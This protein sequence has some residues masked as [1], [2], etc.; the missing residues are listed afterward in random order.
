MQLVKRIPYWAT[1]ALLI[2]MPFHVFLSQSLSL[3]TGGLSEW[4]LAKD[5]ILILV[6]MFAVCTVWIWRKALTPFNLLIV[7]G[8]LYGCLHV[9]LWMAHPHLYRPSALLGIVYNNRLWLYVALGMSAMLLLKPKKFDQRFWL[10]LVLGISTVVTLL[11]VVQYFLPHD[12]LTHLGYGLDRGTLPS[13]F[14]DNRPNFPRIMATLRDPNSLGAYLIVPL[15]L[16]TALL[17][18]THVPKHRWIFGGLLA[19]HAAALFLTF[20]RSAWLAAAVAIALLVFWQYASLAAR[21]TKRWW[22]VLIGLVLLGCVGFYTA[23]NTYVLK[24]V[25]SHRTGAPQGA[26]YDSN[27]FHWV[28]VKRGIEGVVHNPFGHGPGTAGLASIQNPKGSFLTENYYVQVAYEVGVVGLLLFIAINVV[29]YRSLWLRRDMVLSAA[30]ICSFWAYFIMNMLL[31]TW[32]NEA[33]AAQWWLLAGLV[34][35]GTAV[36][37]RKAK[38]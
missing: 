38:V 12:I 5:V 15:T 16:L 22:P 4:K 13:F 20:S 27:G 8:V 29:I 17:M 23:R 19:L 32:S 37:K 9:L 1:T 2:Y 30:L 21:L 18:R 14:I 3:I 7:L 26:E 36:A 10:K 6:S 34:V 25:V 33:V 35:G 11:G 28:F 31:H 24:S